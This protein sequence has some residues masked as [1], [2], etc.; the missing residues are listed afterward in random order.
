MS[1]PRSLLVS[2]LSISCTPSCGL[3]LSL[4]ITQ[5]YLVAPFHPF[6]GALWVFLLLL[7]SCSVSS[8][9]V[10]PAG[11]E[12]C[13]LCGCMALAGGGIATAKVWPGLQ[14][15]SSSLVKGSVGYASSW[16]RPEGK[17]G[18]TGPYGPREVRKSPG[19]F[20]CSGTFSP[21]NSHGFNPSSGQE[22]P[23]LASGF[24]LSCISLSVLTHPAS[25]LVCSSLGWTLDQRW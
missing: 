17:Q 10:P 3:L 5:V 22:F 11:P 18:K 12:G 14:E 19:S 2:S 4:R 24:L 16:L 1:L 8:A 25:L 6:L 23:F 9:H 7:S 15:S 13:R 20:V 21:L